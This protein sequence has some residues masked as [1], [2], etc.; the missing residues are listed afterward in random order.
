MIPGEVT[1]PRLAAHHTL[2]EGVMEITV[3][4]HISD[5]LIQTAA[6]STAAS[7]FR[8]ASY[9]NRGGEGYLVVESQVK[10]AVAALDFTEIATA[11]AQRFAQGIVED[12]TKAE[13]KR[14]ASKIV[15]DMK[16]D[17]SLLAGSAAP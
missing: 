3:T 4:I 12:I 2:Q 10:A 13:L 8:V 5:E 9:G 6:N 15:R 16:E 7:M 1:P 17:G 14:V 11:T